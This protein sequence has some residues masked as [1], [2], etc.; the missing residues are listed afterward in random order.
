MKIYQTLLLFLVV[1]LIQTRKKKKKKTKVENKPID[2][3]DKRPSNISPELFCDACLAIVKEAAKE[4]RGKKKESD[5]L[6]VLENACDSERY[7][8]YRKTYP[9]KFRS[10][11]SRN[12]GRL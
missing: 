9:L 11:P 8:T 12:E 2:P 6:E 10:P 4:L 5:V 7:Y 3:K 1:S